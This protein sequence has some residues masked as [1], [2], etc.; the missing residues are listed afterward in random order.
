MRV[1]G[2][3]ELCRGGN[4]GEQDKNRHVFLT[5]TV[6]RSALSQDPGALS[7]SLKH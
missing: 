4:D 6:F 5:L 3:W 7:W 2:G 1:E